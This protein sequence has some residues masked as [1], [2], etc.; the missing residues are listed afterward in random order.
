MTLL[1]KLIEAGIK[2][3]DKRTTANK[4]EAIFNEIVGY[5]DIKKEFTKALN[6]SSPVGILLCGPPGCGKSEFL[7]QIA[8]AFPEQ[9]LFID[10]TYG[11]K[12]GIFDKLKNTKP[13]YLILDE[14][15]KLKGDDQQA[16]YNLM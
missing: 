10:G 5:S 13:K 12:A 9:S 11:S 6:A 3:L 2:I 1:T 4:N 14:I 7:K 16:L 15:D 8:K